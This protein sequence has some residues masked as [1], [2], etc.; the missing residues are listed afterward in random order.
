[1]PWFAWVAIIAILVWGGISIYGMASGKPLPWSEGADKD[2][3]EKLRQRVK[4]LEAGTARP[5]LEQ[6]IDRLEARVDKRELRDSAHDDWERRARD[7]GLDGRG[8]GQQ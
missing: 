2:E 4:A 7:L 5:E 6:R 3:L 8:P 1:M